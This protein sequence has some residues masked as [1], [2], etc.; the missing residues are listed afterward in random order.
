MSRVTQDQEIRTYLEVMALRL[1]KYD[2]FFAVTNLLTSAAK[3]MGNAQH[4]FNG[5]R[6]DVRA[7]FEDC[8]LLGSDAV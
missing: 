5:G 2:L 6:L 8:C 1:G 3:K 4:L 7:P